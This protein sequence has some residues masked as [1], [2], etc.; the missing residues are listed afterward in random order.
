[1]KLFVPLEASHLA[2][3]LMKAYAPKEGVKLRDVLSNSDGEPRR[4]RTLAEILKER[5]RF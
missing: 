1:V 4:A 3:A 5:G 2:T